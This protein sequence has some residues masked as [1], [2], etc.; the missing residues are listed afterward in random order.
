MAPGHEAAG[1]ETSKESWIVTRPRSILMDLPVAFRWEVTR[2]H[3]CYLRF[4]ELA[5]RRHTDPGTDP[6]QLALEESAVAIL[7]AI[8]VSGDPP[9]PGSS[10][11]SLGA[12]LGQAWESGAVAPVTFRGLVGMLLADLPADLLLR[13]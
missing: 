8:G 7:L 3:P 10:P 6:Q 11:E 4:W 12:G 13:V 5:H 1:D 9:P 2:R